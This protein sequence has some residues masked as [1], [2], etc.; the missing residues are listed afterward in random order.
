MSAGI[1]V[2]IHGGRLYEADA[3]VC[4]ATLPGLCSASDA[5]DEVRHRALDRRQGEL[6]LQVLFDSCGPNS[7]LASLWPRLSQ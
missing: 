2:P 5:D 3:R 6:Y 1:G 7:S 4:E